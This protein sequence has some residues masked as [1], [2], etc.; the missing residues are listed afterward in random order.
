MD[1][2][3]YVNE[4]GESQLIPRPL[5]CL[6]V[7]TSGSGKTNLLLNFIYN[8]KGLKFKNLYVFS[9]SI[10][11]TAYTNL[12]DIYTKVESK[13]GRKIAYFYSDCNDL[14]T[15]DECQPN[16]L[17]VFDDCLLEK[18]TPI[19]DY[20]IRGRH[21][22]I[23][24]VYLSQSYGRVDMQVIRNNINLLCVFNQNKHY[25]KRIY[26]DFVG[27]DMSYIEF[28]L[29]CKQCWSHPH[30]FISIDTSKKAHRGKYKCMLKRELTMR[31]RLHK[32]VSQLFH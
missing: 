20:F 28:E 4:T 16:S 24:C 25:S 21:K 1:I 11:Q 13:L 8:D 10:T 9:R 14:I 23:S 5:R 19:K 7:G 22:Q 6:I 12:Q 30:G 15:V 17:V 29:F 2:Q 26:D 27:S 32:D 31:G 18:Q 3:V